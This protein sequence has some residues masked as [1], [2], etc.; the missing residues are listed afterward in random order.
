MTLPVKYANHMKA[1]AAW[2]K[3][4]QYTKQ[5]IQAAADCDTADRDALYGEMPEAFMNQLT[6]DLHKLYCMAYDMQR[7]K[8]EVS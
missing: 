4:V 7:A 3:A 8:E 1:D 6:D 2:R 5:I